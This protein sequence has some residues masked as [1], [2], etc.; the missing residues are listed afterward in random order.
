MRKSIDLYTGLFWLLFSLVVCS[1]AYRLKLGDI[2]QP[3]PGFF[4][5]WAAVIMGILSL[6]VVLQSFREKVDEGAV[7]PDEP[8]GF[9][10]IMIALA[11]LTA[12]FLSLEKIGFLLNTFLFMAIMLKLV[13][14]QSWRTSLVSALGTAIAA[15]LLF[16][17][18]L[19]AQIPNGIIQFFL[20]R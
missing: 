19:K 13:Y 7:V 5:F 8:F 6:A 11:V 4:P 17:V 18:V 12:Y 16:N 15:Q 2:H 1:E 9:R 14:S 10:K 3:G 20:G